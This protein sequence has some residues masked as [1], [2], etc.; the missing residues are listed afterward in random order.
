MIEIAKLKRMAELI[1]KNGRAPG[2]AGTIY[3]PV[4]M[5]VKLLGEGGRI[6]DAVRLSLE[7]GPDDIVRIKNGEMELIEVSDEA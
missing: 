7:A 5:V 6:T 2:H 4:S 1:S 3:A